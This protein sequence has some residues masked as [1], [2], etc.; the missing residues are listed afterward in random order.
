MNAAY[1]N[2]RR[3]LPLIMVLA[4][5]PTAFAQSLVET[6]D[7]GPISA[8][9]TNVAVGEY[10]A[11]DQAQYGP[12]TSVYV[13]I[14]GDLSGTGSFLGNGGTPSVSVSESLSTNTFSAPISLTVTGGVSE[15]SPLA[16]GST[17]GFSF[18]GATL[19]GSAVITSNLAN[20]Q[21]S[22]TFNVNIDAGTP[23]VTV[24]G[25]SGINYSPL[26]A[27]SAYPI[28]GQIIVSYNSPYTPVPEPRDWMAL[29]LAGVGCLMV[30][31]KLRA[32]A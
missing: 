13:Y 1:C 9:G 32:K 2:F 5:A 27:N 17:Q 25:A 10:M 3:I 22:G 28:S 19:T 16:N 21:G 14:T 4:M 20:Y 8:T 15:S 24:S 31:R 11:A 12:L 26:N 18:T 30:V 29:M 6:V 7:F 23:Q